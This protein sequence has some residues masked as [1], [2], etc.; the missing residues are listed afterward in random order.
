M[1]STLT[2]TLVLATGAFLIAAEIH[3]TQHG[4]LTVH[5]W[6]TFT[7]VAGEDGSAIDWDTL[8]G[9]DD[10]PAFVNNVG[11]RCFK[12]RLAG[13]VRMET[14]VMYFYSQRE[15]TARVKVQFPHGVITE[16]YPKGDNA[17]YESKSLIDRLAMPLTSRIYSNDAI[18]QTKSL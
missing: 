9:K 5:E 2:F 10:L 4:D 11:Y 6:G 17:I 14:P 13:T 15:V 1:K 3:S 18:Y 16:W 7:S 12:W 8:G